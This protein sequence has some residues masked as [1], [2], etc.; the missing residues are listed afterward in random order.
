MG[1]PSRQKDST[2][3]LTKHPSALHGDVPGAPLPNG[4]AKLKLIKAKELIQAD[5]N[6]KSDPYA[7]LVYGSQVEKTKVIQNCH[8]PEWNHEAEFDFPDGDERC[9]YVEVF[10]SDK[11]G[12]DTSLGN[13]SL[14]ITDILALDGTKGKWFPLSGV[15]SGK[16]LL[17][18]E[19]LDQLGRKASDILPGLLK[20]GDNDNLGA[21]KDSKT[22]DFPIS[23]LPSGKAKLHVIKA[24][25]LIK[26]DIVGKSDPYAVLIFGKQLQ[27]TK[28]I[29]N[30]SEPEWNHEAEF[31]V[32]DGASRN[33]YIEVFD[34]DK[35]GK[36]KTLGKLN[37]DITDVLS[38]A[39]QG[40]K[41]FPLTGVKSGELLL[42]ADFIDEL[43]RKASD[44]LPGILKGGSTDPSRQKDSTSPSTKH[45]SALHGDVPGAP[46]PNG[47]AKL[48]LIKA[49]E[50]IQA[51]KNSKSDPY[52]MLVYGSQVEKTKVI[53][54]CH[55]PEWNHE[56]EFDF[57]DGDERCFYV[58]VFDSD[59]V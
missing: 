43:G 31:D 39:D 38:L 48:K 3:P 47:K 54:N 12:K 18:A 45:P 15:P 4:K 41:W 33:F 34:S 35:L 5:N 53:Q 28:T 30:T 44:I 2:S 21:R 24:R 9:F 36:D 56:A 50:L 19:F 59:K 40:G 1:D 6:S 49:T 17:S 25:N 26:A 8:E 46:L 20:G 22:G 58:E 14:D 32:P 27:K 51:D 16:V 7:M 57:P 42:T 55:E 52:A 10:D 23:N 11:V 29:R 37:L 13:L